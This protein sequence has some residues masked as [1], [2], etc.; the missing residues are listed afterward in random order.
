MVSNL[1]DYAYL[2]E[3]EIRASGEYG[4]LKQAYEQVLQNSQAKT[5]FDDFRNLQL[6]LQEKQMSGQPVTEKEAGQAQAIAAAVQAN[7]LIARLMNAEQRLS[8]VL[9]EVNKILMKPLEDLYT[10]K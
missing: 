10:G 7:P 6:R 9:D 5:L 3:K 4:A 1:N 2:L 8:A